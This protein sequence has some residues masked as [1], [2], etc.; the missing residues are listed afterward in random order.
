MLL[1]LD[2]SGIISSVTPQDYTGRVSGSGSLSV[3][4][5]M[6]T[7]TSIRRNDEKYYACN[8]KA[9]DPGKDDGFDSVYLFVEGE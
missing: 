3:G 1:F 7:L 5:A 8:L 2:D 4:Q 6:F 9:T